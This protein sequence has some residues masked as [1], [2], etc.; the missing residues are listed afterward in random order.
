MTKYQSNYINTLTHRNGCEIDINS[1]GFKQHDTFTNNAMFE[2]SWIAMSKVKCEHL[3]RIVQMP[4]SNVSR[5]K[6]SAPGKSPKFI[7]KDLG[8]VVHESKE[9]TGETGLN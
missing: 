2:P 3:G 4:R 5:T 9:E 1:N 7:G 8:G 6:A